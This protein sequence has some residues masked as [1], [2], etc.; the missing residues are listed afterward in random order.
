V[1]A[2]C[3]L[4]KEVCGADFIEADLLGLDEYE[5]FERDQRVLLSEFYFCHLFSLAKLL[6]S[7]GMEIISF[8]P[9]CVK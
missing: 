5:L 3:F 2:L 7:L 1:L 8:L 6:G 4:L 9:Y